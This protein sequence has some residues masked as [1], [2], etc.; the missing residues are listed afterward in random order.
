MDNSFMCGK[1]GLGRLVLVSFAGGLSAG[2]LATLAYLHGG[3]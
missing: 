3:A 2:I 1:S